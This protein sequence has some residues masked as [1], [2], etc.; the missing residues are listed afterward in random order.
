MEYVSKRWSPH[1]CT[2]RL[3]SL[4]LCDLSVLAYFLSMCFSLRACGHAYCFQCL[5]YYFADRVAQQAN[6][7]DNRRRIPRHLRRFD[8]ATVTPGHLRRLRKLL[9][10]F[11]Y[12]CPLCRISIS[13]SDHPIVVPA[14]QSIVTAVAAVTRTLS[15]DEEGLPV[16][17][18]SKGTWE[19]LFKV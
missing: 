10:R 14:L 18:A 4:P 15:S 3:L 8:P 9:P 12:A 16:I 7:D 17:T 19:G 2:S 6:H 5:R 13:Y 1:T 11:E